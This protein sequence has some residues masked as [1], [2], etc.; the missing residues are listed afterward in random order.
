MVSNLI[1]TVALQVFCNG[2]RATPK[3]TPTRNNR[4]VELG[5]LWLATCHVVEG[6]SRG[7]PNLAK[8]IERKD[9]VE[10]TGVYYEPTHR[11][12]SGRVD[13]AGVEGSSSAELQG[14]EV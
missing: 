8:A 6:L 13:P 7:K 9:V 10:V 4:V 12:E 5:R 11:L 3:L 14:G 2:L 1:G